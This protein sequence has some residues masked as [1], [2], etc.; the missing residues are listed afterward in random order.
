VALWSV[1][2]SI[3]AAQHGMPGGTAMTFF[4]TTVCSQ[5]D[6]VSW[7]GVGLFCCFAVE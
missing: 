4:A 2:L 5:R 3:A 6:L 7:G 1:T